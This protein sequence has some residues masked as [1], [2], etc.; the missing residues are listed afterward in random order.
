MPNITILQA[1]DRPN[2]RYLLL[3]QQVNKKVCDH[4]GYKYLFI[5]IDKN[6][7]TNVHPA[8]IKIYIVNEFLNDVSNHKDT[9]DTKD[10]ILIFLD[11]DAWVQNGFWLDEIIKQ[12]QNN[13]EKQG[14]FSRD[15]YLKNNTF[16][17]SGSFVLKINDY[18]KK[19]YNEIINSLEKDETNSHYKNSW[20]YDQF[21]I[22][23]YVFNHKE[24]FYTFIPD[25]LNTPV[26]KVLRHN[27]WK[28]KRMYDDLHYL[29]ANNVIEID[30]MYFFHI[31]NSV[32]DLKKYID[33]EVFPNTDDNAYKYYSI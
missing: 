2:L 5:T 1:D 27:W 22:S 21:Y 19:M 25:I 14:C 7:Y 3:T 26:G 32:L 13:V 17:N 8:I 30:K 6:K 9:D 31:Y 11:S 20:P 24:D 12:L 28:N 29:I 10:D 18:T 16:I 4:F 23:N 33:T 15:P